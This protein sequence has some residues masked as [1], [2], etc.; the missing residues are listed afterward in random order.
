MTEMSATMEIR[1]SL[2]LAMRAALA[3]FLIGAGT[4]A[5]ATACSTSITLL[6][7][8]NIERSSALPDQEAP[9]RDLI[10]GGV[11]V[12]AGPER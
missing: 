3:V 1:C 9:N 10:I 6:P 5:A 7:S 2:K 4:G 11:R 12:V 8:D